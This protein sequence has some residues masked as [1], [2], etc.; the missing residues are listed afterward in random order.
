[1]IGAVRR[2]VELAC[3]VLMAAITGVVFLQV[4]T[5]YVFQH[6]FEWPEEIARYCFVWVAML[7][8]ALGLDRGVHFSIDMLTTRFRPAVAARV[9]IAI[10]LVCAGFC[11]LLAW[12]GALLTW[13]VRE[14][15]SVALELP[16]AWAYAAIPVGAALMAASLVRSAAHR[17]RRRRPAGA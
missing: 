10:D 2:A 12:Q 3:A 7:G 11:A 1:M 6:P 8:A 15:P 4:L 9:A 14:Q 5:R 16:M 17:A 13:A